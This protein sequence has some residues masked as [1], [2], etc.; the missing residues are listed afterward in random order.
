MQLLESAHSAYVHSAVCEIGV[1]P[2]NFVQS[3][4]GIYVAALCWLCVKVCV[5]YMCTYICV[6][7]SLMKRKYHRIVV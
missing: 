7:G 2:F 1:W 5:F 6:K 4:N 3:H